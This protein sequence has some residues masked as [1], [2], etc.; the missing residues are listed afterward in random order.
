MEKRPTTK[1]ERAA[2]TMCKQSPPAESPDGAAAVTYTAFLDALLT[3]VCCADNGTIG[4]ADS[5]TDFVVSGSE[6][7]ARPLS[8]SSDDED[9]NKLNTKHENNATT[10]DKEPLAESILPHLRFNPLM[11]MPSR[12][13]ANSLTSTSSLDEFF[14]LFLKD[15][16][17]H[18]FLSFHKSKGD[19]DIKA[20]PWKMGQEEDKL[21][22]TITFITKFTPKNLQEEPPQE[23]DAATTPSSSSSNKTITD[24]HNPTLTLAVT[25]H[26]TLS[27]QPS[28]MILESLLSFNF[29]DY[30][31][32]KTS[33]SK[34]LNLSLTQFLISNDVKGSEVNVRVVLKEEDGGLTASTVAADAA[35]GDQPVIHPFL[36]PD[37]LPSLSEDPLSGN[38]LEQDNHNN[39][40]T[41]GG[42]DVMSGNPCVS[43]THI[44][45][46]L[47]SAIRAR[48]C[49]TP[50]N[51]TS[52]RNSSPVDEAALLIA[53]HSESITP[54]Q[55]KKQGS[56]S[57][58]LQRDNI[59]DDTYDVLRTA[60]SRGSLKFKHVSSFEA[61]IH[62][63]EMAMR[64]MLWEKDRSG[65]SARGESNVLR[66]DN[67][68]TSEGGEPSISSLLQ[69]FD[70][71]TRGG[72]SMHIEME[73]RDN[74]SSNNN[75][76]SNNTTL[77]RSLSL[78]NRSRSNNNG[79]SSSFQ[80]SRSNGLG[81]PSIAYIEEKVRKGLKKRV[82]R[83]WIT[84]ANSWCCRLWEDEQVE[85]FLKKG[86]KKPHPA[87]GLARKRSNTRPTVRRIGER[88]KKSKSPA[89]VAK[90][91]TAPNNNLNDE[92]EKLSVMQKQIQ[93]A[94]SLKPRRVVT[95]TSSPTNRENDVSLWVPLQDKD[96]NQ[97]CRW[98]SS[99]DE[100]G[101]YG[102]EVC[103]ISPVDKSKE[104]GGRTKKFIR[105]LKP[106]KSKT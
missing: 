30:S 34:M 103:T 36:L 8:D 82:A 47:L 48:N 33:L 64:R 51:S 60:S 77:R 31:L 72:L 52:K 39:N 11:S 65:S 86:S 37:R 100:E 27:R 12:N 90:K 67:T 80:R 24:I 85:R 93:S 41:S 104:T 83:S 5:T 18:S 29:V 70:L 9:G 28:T 3:N 96:G 16:A 45:A 97:S 54:K 71:S 102:V 99:E 59:V 44:G 74:S 43:P 38:S 10:I 20:T 14:D 35:S 17:P 6:G 49:P 66:R 81:G 95:P 32:L 2:T 22:R 61:G 69:P 94:K 92:M 106:N 76:N 21:E 79:N 50:P 13:N 57:P 91:Q 55:K 105:G 25:A 87:P 68:N 58:S 15:D 42:Y 26:Q 53:K 78:S 23:K 1:E 7:D 46:S 75:N 73:V 89:R 101:Q 63:G 56:S 40:C 98:M 62:P 84:W 88:K 19:E 4:D